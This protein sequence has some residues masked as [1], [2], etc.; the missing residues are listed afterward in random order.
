MVQLLLLIG[1]TGL[2]AGVSWFAGGYLEGLHAGDKPAASAIEA[3]A[4]TAPK[5]AARTTPHILEID[6]ITT[7]LAEPSEIWVRAELSL[8][9]DGEPDPV[10]AAAVH[11]DL[12]A[13]IRT[14]RLRQVETAS[15]FQ[16]L[17]SDL[18]ERA[19]IR[20]DGA[21]K[22]ILLRTLLFE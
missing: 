13:Y 5:D 15:G 14:V 21:V 2:A 9:F 12:F 6:P 11:Q 18:E 19:R 1:M 16:H 4:H 22:A 3:D 10:V 7:N 8:V 17:R 20:S